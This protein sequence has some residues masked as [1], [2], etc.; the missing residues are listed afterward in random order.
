MSGRRAA[1]KVLLTLAILTLVVSI[2]G[3]IGSILLN[4]FAFDKY[5]AYGEVPVPGQT[6]LH[7][8]AGQV[9]VT[10]HTRT[11]GSPGGGG[12]P[13]PDLGISIDPPVWMSRRGRAEPDTVDDADTDNPFGPM[14]TG[15]PQRAYTPADEGIRIEQLK[16]LA[17][18]R[19]SGALTR[20]E[21]EQEKRRVL[22]GS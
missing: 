8:P 17:A 7:L 9:N 13:I 10:F 18:L 15:S 14:V 21:F 6:S 2:V 12:L 3:F 20:E 16:H 22:D 5:D 4:A 1:P 19:D 11:V